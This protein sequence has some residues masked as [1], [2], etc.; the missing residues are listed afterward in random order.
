MDAATVIGP[1]FAHYIQAEQD[2]RCSVHMREVRGL[3]NSHPRPHV[4][5][6]PISPWLLAAP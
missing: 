1:F 5:P 4:V 2:T 6:L 3:E